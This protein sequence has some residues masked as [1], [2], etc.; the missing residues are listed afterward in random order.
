MGTCLPTAGR[1]EGFTQAAQGG[2]DLREA[3]A[4]NPPRARRMWA[5]WAVKTR[6]KR[7]SPA[8]VRLTIMLRPS[9]G[10]A[11]RRTSFCASRRSITPV[12]VPLVMSVFSPSSLKLMPGV[13]PSV[14]TMSNCEG[15]S[16]R[17]RT[18]VEE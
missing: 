1:V 10:E 2:L 16:P 5:R 18:W 14:A 3:L 9:S 13:L 8:G 6:S 4:S 12:S 15:V 11:L 7:R 17:L